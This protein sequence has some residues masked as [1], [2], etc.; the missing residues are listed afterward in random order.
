M[1][2]GGGGGGRRGLLASPLSGAL[3]PSPSGP[4][5]PHTSNMAHAL[6]T[7]VAYAPTAR[8]PAARAPSPPRVPASARSGIGSSS[9]GGGSGIGMRRAFGDDDEEEEAMAPPR[10]GLGVARG[11]APGLAGRNP[12]AAFVRPA[13][14]AQQTEK[15][16]GIGG[17]A[18]GEERVEDVSLQSASCRVVD[19]DRL[20]W[21]SDCCIRLET[22][23]AAG[24]KAA[25]DGGLR[26]RA[27][28]VSRAALLSICSRS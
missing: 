16:G 10:G 14:Q 23:R 1:A 17:A 24:Q 7:G 13:V 4:A 12:A 28:A 5:P 27:G 18:F 25:R 6:L 20:L 22:Q 8:A 26:W 19:T 3:A 2:I 21:T 15:R 11:L 9:S